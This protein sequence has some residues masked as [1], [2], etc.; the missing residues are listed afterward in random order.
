MCLL[1]VEH[2]VSVEPAL[3]ELLHGL[4]G[5]Q[6]GTD[7]HKGLSGGHAQ[8]PCLRLR[9]SDEEL[10]ARGRVGAQRAQQRRGD[11]AGSCGADTAQAHAGVLGL[12]HDADTTGRK[13]PFEVIGNLLGQPLL[14]LATVAVEVHQASE[15]GQAQDPVRGKVTHVRHPDERQHVVFTD[16]PDGDVLDQDQFVVP[17]GVGKGGEVEAAGSEHLGVAWAI[18]RGVLPMPPDSTG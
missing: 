8:H 6:P 4:A 2:E 1:A 10:S 11:R 13:V 18:R 5:S 14:R 9:A 16:R 3:S 17:L 7:D 15:L 12:D